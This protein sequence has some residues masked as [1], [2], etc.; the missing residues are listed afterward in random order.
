MVEAEAFVMAKEYRATTGKRLV[1]ALM[2]LAAR[3]GLGNFVV[4][5]TTGSRS[6][7]PRAVTLSPIS[8]EDG[9]HLVSPYGDSGWVHNVRANPTATLRRGRSEDRVRLVEVTEDKPELV[10]AYYE[11]EAFSRQFM[12]VPGEADVEDFATVAGRFPVFRIER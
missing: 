11:R 2:A 8:D 1:S 3:T 9:E 10:K 12:D 5:T 6:G 4:L 7:Q